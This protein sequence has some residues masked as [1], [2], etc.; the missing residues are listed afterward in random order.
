MSKKAKAV[1]I[2]L[3][4]DVKAGVFLEGF[5]DV[6]AL[7]GLMV[8]EQGGHDSGQGQGAAVEGVHELDVAVLVLEAATS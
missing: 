2:K 6:N 4:D 8:F 1:M 3:R 5:R 7:G